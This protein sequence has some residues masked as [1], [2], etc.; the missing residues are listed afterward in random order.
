MWLSKCI[1]KWAISCSY[2]VY[3]ATV[4]I[5][6]TNCFAIINA[7]NIHI[8]C[9]CPTVFQLLIQ[10]IIFTQKFPIWIL[11]S[12]NTRLSPLNKSRSEINGWTEMIPLNLIISICNVIINSFSSRLNNF[13]S[14]KLPCH[15]YTD[16]ANTLRLLFYAPFMVDYGENSTHSSLSQHHRHSHPI[17]MEH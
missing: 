2:L 12:G 4:T 5:Q 6:H 13:R 3:V 8:R 10:E 16:A 7:Y 14:L 17:H 9:S 15:L 1:K 11:I